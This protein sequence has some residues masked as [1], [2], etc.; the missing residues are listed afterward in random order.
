VTAGQRYARFATKVAVRRPALWRVLRTPL[1]LMFDRMAPQWDE[2]RV[3]ERYLAPLGAALDAVHGSPARILDVGTGTGAAARVAAG[4]WPE[5]DVLGLDMSPGMI[6]E[7][8]ARG[9]ANQ[10]YEVGDASS[11][12]VADS[13]IDLVVMVNMIPFFDELARVLVPG[14]TLVMAFS[15]GPDTPIWVP[16]DHVAA[17]L[18]TR[19][20]TAIQRFSAGIGQS[21]L[22]V[23]PM[24]S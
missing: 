16:L 13:S 17:E 12:P 21:L 24:R 22:A 1:R 18:E 19:G 4:R 6:D 14:G 11:L 7:A 2:L 5:A 8:R 9:G 15:S 10:R 3:T 20:L 23:R